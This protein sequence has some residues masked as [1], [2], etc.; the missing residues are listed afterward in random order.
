[1]SGAGR[2]QY[3]RGQFA[4]LRRQN[5]EHVLFVERSGGGAIKNHLAKLGVGRIKSGEVVGL[6]TV[7]VNRRIETALSRGGG[8][9]IPDRYATIHQS[10]HS[11]LIASGRACLKQCAHDHPKGV[12]GLRIVLSLHQRRLPGEG[13]QDQYFGIL[14]RNGGETF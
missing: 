8:A 7:G 3:Q 11:L 1:M 10:L 6:D 4:A 13:T 12:A 5:G 14:R 2:G 9:N